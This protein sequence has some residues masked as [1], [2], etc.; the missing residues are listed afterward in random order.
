MESI[1]KPALDDF[2]LEEPFEKVPKDK[3][4][5]ERLKK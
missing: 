1:T 4:E 3:D 5:E 2:G